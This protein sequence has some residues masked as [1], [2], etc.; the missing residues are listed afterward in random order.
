LLSF[1]LW[2]EAH[3]ERTPGAVRVPEVLAAR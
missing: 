1:T 2:H 3:V